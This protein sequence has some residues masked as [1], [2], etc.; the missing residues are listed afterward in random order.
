MRIKIS[1]D[2]TCDLPSGLLDD[3]E[4][5]TVPYTITLGDDAY[6]DGVN[7]KPGDIFRFV[8]ETGKLPGT[9]APAPESYREK[10]ELWAEQ[11]ETVVHIGMGEN[12][13]SGL[14]NARIAAAEYPNV[15]VVDS[16]NLSAGYGLLVLEAAMLAKTSITPQELVEKVASLAPRINVSFVLSRLDY[17][18]KGGRC[19]MVEMLGANLLKIKPVLEVRNGKLVMAKKY[20][21]NYEKVLKD[22]VA[23]CLKGRDDILLHRMFVADAC[24]DDELTLLLEDEVRKYAEFEEIYHA[25]GGCTVSS[26]CGRPCAGIMYITK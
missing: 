17:M 2:S 7:I 16:E 26:H 3:Y 24:E 14:R 15:Y 4:I 23:D 25:K 18:R 5:S 1:A 20:R 22:Y 19:T 12:F 6:L 11:N 13:S 10:F 8:D 9:A 21:G